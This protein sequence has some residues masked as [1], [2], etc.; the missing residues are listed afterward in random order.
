MEIISATPGP[1][2]TPPLALDQSACLH[3]VTYFTTNFSARSGASL[4]MPCHK[5]SRGNRCV[6]PAAAL[7]EP[8]SRAPSRT[9]MTYVR[10]K[11][12]IIDAHTHK[13]KVLP[14]T[15]PPHQ[16]PSAS[17]ASRPPPPRPAHSETPATDLPRP[18]SLCFRP[19]QQPPVRRAVCG[20]L[21]CL[22][23]LLLCLLQRR[24]LQR[25]I[26]PPPPSMYG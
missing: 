12:F 6:S 13:H 3:T 16:L 2:R 20:L 15:S 21:L 11:H 23:G 25:S 26:L 9:Y 8:I 1:S 4:M 7:G 18:V 24:V 17:E 5:L 22:L 10:C 19:C 14:T